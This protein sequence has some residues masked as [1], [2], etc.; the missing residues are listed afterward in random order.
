MPAASMTSRRR[1][2]ARAS[3][4]AR[5]SSGDTVRPALAQERLAAGP[6][7]D[8]EE[9]VLVE[10]VAGD[11]EQARTALRRAFPDP[12]AVVLV[13]WAR[14]RCERCRESVA[15]RHEAGDRGG[16]LGLS[17]TR[18]RVILAD[19][20]SHTG[21]WSQKRGR[22]VAASCERSPP[23]VAASIARAP[24]GDESD[25]SATHAPDLRRTRRIRGTRAGSAALASDARAQRTAGSPA[26]RGSV[27]AASEPPPAGPPS[28]SSIAWACPTLRSNGSVSVT[29]WPIAASAASTP[30]LKRGS[31]RTSTGGAKCSPASTN[32]R[33]AAT[34]VATSTPPSTRAE[35]TW[36]WICGW[37]SPPIDPAT[38]HGS[39]SPA[40]KSIPGMSVWSV[41]L[42]GARTFGCAGSRL[43]Y[44]PRFW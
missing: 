4:G 36:A 42:R 14:L 39:R 12:P 34:A 8:D 2:A 25:S 11:V 33:G 20:R 7:A 23:P 31:A 17:L 40:R 16:P 19:V 41:R 32:Q 1:D 37:A 29:G 18:V 44:E 15:L 13:G 27:A 28:T 35:T 24:R 21:S 38:I 30:G 10:R 22:P 43:K 3:L 5:I 26:L 9:G 6:V